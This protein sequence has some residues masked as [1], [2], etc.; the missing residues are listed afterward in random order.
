MASTL[1]DCI[2]NRHPANIE[3]EVNLDR[4]TGHRW[5]RFSFQPISNGLGGSSGLYGS[6]ED[7]THTKHLAQELSRKSKSLNQVLNT[8]TDG[9]FDLNEDLQIESIDALARPLILGKEAFVH[10]AAIADVLPTLDTQDLRKR[11]AELKREGHAKDFEFFNTRTERWL[12]FKFLPRDEGMTVLL[13]DITSRKTMYRDLFMVG[14]AI[15]Q[16]NEVIMVTNDLASNPTSF[17]CIYLNSAFEN[18]TGQV[19]SRWLG[20]NPYPLIADRLPLRDFRKLLVHLLKREKLTIKTR[21]ETDSGTYTPCEILVSPFV[22]KE[23]GTPW[24]LIVF[25]PAST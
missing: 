17:Q 12:R 11:Q 16:I 10:H 22:D 2:N 5:F 15:E 21:Y 19:V 8:L 24:S 25:R 20:R 4:L 14:S 23:S 1:I 13:R 6:V 18:V 7:I 9:T 3:C